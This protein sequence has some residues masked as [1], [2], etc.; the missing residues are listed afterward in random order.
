MTLRLVSDAPGHDLPPRWD[1]FAVA[2]RGWEERPS[3]TFICGE[4]DDVCGSCGRGDHAWSNACERCGSDKPPSSNVGLIGD[5]PK[6]TA[7]EITRND[8]AIDL[9][10]R[11]GRVKSMPVRLGWMR[12]TVFRCPDCGLDTVVDGDEVWTLDP[13]DYGDEG[14]VA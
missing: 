6:L 12:L 11:T 14:S 2:W 5:D 13:D 3:P 1:G 7:D 10:S 9:A 4:P 8:E